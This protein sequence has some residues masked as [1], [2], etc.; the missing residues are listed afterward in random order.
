MNDRDTVY[1]QA[2][3]RPT[4]LNAIEIL[5]AKVDTIAIENLDQVGQLKQEIKKA[6]RLN[7]ELKQEVSSLKKENRE[8]IDKSILQEI[9][10]MFVIYF[11]YSKRAHRELREFVVCDE[12]TGHFEADLRL[13]YKTLDRDISIKRMF[14]EFYQDIA[15]FEELR[16]S[17]SWC[18]VPDKYPYSLET[19]RVFNNN[20]QEYF[21]NLE[22]RIS[23]MRN[24]QHMAVNL[25]N[26]LGQK[27]NKADHVNKVFE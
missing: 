22:T 17:C 18:R 6:N 20:F 14:I 12:K 16:Q 2:E 4:S 24:N 9:S 19:I 8:Q 23:M 13:F 26:I 1:V 11:L 15:P 5:N 27:I 10:E 25:V 7:E 21:K 3:Q